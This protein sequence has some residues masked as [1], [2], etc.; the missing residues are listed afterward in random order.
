MGNTNPNVEVVKAD[1]F[2]IQKYVEK[3]LLIQGRKF[4]IRAWALIATDMRCYFFKEGYIR[5]ASELF[6]LDK[7]VSSLD[8]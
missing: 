7:D 1:S 2:V 8:S 5:T 3:P 6:S 4:D